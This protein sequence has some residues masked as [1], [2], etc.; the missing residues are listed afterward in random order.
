[1]KRPE[2]RH[3]GEDKHKDAEEKGLE[4]RKGLSIVSN[5]GKV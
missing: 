4:E 5:T 2:A 3:P 1:M